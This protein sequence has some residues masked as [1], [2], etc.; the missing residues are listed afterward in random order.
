MTIATKMIGETQNAGS[1]TN[2]ETNTPCSL[3]IVTCFD[4]A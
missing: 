4:R 1:V 3:I 2:A